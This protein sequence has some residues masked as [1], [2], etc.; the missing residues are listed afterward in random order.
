MQ[1]SRTSAS[2]ATIATVSTPRRVY[3][4][5]A[6]IGVAQLWMAHHFYGFLTGDEVEVLSEAFRSA[7]GFKYDLWDVRN[8]F[9]PDLLV[10]P[11]IRA[12]SALGIHD[13]AMLIDIA[14]VPFV[15]ASAVTIVL[16]YRLA[17]KWTSDRGASAAATLV[18]ALHWIPLGYG[19]TTY[20][21][22]IAMACITGAALLVMSETPIAAICAGLLMGVAFADRYSEIV[23]LLPILVVARR[24]AGWVLAGATASIALTVGLTDL[25]RWG[26]P[27]SSLRKFAELTLVV[28]DFSSRVKYQ[29]PLWY[30]ETLPRWCSPALL[31][32]LWTARRRASLWMFIVVPLGVLSLIGHK[33]LRYL[34]CLI[35]FLAILAGAGYAAWTP[36]HRRAAQ[37][38]LVVAVAWSLWGMRFLERESMPAVEAA[39][40]I[41]RD[42]SVRVIAIS[43]PWACG[44]NLY[45]TDRRA[46]TE[47]K[48]PPERLALALAGSD[49]A[50]IYESDLTPEVRDTVTRSGFHA[51]R[52]YRA[53]RARDVVVFRATGR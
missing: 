6:A 7:T 5:A 8:T 32:F 16:V 11:L 44:G 15:I 40:D 30:F 19:T 23:F 34:Q 13:T 24:R 12:A 22:V 47:L 48:T 38:L 4:L 21:R 9:V 18:F 31:P 50:L 53:P 28:R 1:E 10:A 3:A 26:S 51:V 41:A 17:W 52:T 45:I 39:R 49:A 27:F 46:A 33:E 2:R 42:P 20:P 43:Q 36:A 29:S 35:P 14:T 37:V 25:I